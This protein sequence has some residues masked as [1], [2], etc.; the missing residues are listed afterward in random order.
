MADLR[1]AEWGGWGYRVN[2]GRTAIVVSGRRGILVERTNGTHFAV[3][4]PDP[5]LAVALLTT[6]AAR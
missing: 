5:E 2:P 6:L 3:T 4:V 1:A